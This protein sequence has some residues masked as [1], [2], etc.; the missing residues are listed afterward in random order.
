MMVVQYETYRS[1]SD[2]FHGQHIG[3]FAS[4]YSGEATL[5]TKLT[6]QV[7]EQV[8]EYECTWQ[9]LHSNERENLITI[10]S[11]L[12]KNKTQL[13]ILTTQ[14]TPILHSIYACKTSFSK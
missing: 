10:I 3:T 12:K 9:S 14:I 2:P 1:Y 11:S 6:V 7:Q 8:I 4:S 13:A 5:V